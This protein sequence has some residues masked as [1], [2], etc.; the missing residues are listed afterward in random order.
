M[1]PMIE[2]KAAFLEECEE[3]LSALE[4]RL[5]ALME[6][7]LATDDVNGAFRAIHSVKGGAGAF[8]FPKLVE[9]THVFEAALDH[10]RA[11]RIA[12]PSAPYDLFL[13][14]LDHVSSMVG[15][16]RQ[17][18]TLEAPADLV[19]ALQKVGMSG[20][21]ETAPVAAAAPVSV[22]RPAS[23]PPRVNA[24]TGPLRIQLRPAHDLFN[25]AIDPRQIFA[26][27]EAFGTLEVAPD[28]AAL[29]DLRALNPQNCHLRLELR[30]ATAA[31]AQSVAEMLELYLD[32]DEFSLAAPM[33]VAP[34]IVAQ[35][36]LNPAAQAAAPAANSAFVAAA[37]VA[38]SKFVSE[39]MTVVAASA[40]PG[41]S[42]NNGPA[43]RAKAAG[44]IR[45][46]LD[47][48]DRLMNLVGEIVITQSMLDQRLLS[49]QVSE[50][51]QIAEG[52]QVLGRQTRELQESVM[53][54]LAQ[55]VKNVF[56]RMPRLVRELAQ[57]LGKHARL[58]VIGEDTEV[59]KT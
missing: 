2:L 33:L 23:A 12:L 59:D 39:N 40:M 4:M 51:M 54:V 25:R 30:L 26:S 42:A 7:S 18:E 36:Q 57:S 11:G 6:G 58:V 3:L 27:L 55:P 20:A 50:T 53:A 1:D 21:T 14:A 28:L 52:L 29:P 5:T 13:Q 16:A 46:D 8:G 41:A 10:L 22:A 17:G 38:Q 45:V 31:P 19:K 9:L 47:R 49:L 32:S 35:A 37:P 15:A 48:I 44:S 34:A 56:Q 43:T 24:E